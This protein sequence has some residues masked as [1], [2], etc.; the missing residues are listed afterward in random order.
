MG[1]TRQDTEYGKAF[2]DRMGPTYDLVNTISAFGFSVWWRIVCV[3]GARP[4]AGDLT[5][6]G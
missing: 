1:E 3:D 4:A 2:F 5:T 6:A